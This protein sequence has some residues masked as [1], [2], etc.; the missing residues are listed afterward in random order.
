MAKKS[1]KAATKK[2]KTRRVVSRRKVA[3]R[4]KTKAKVRDKARPTAKKRARAKPARKSE[5]HGIFAKVSGALH[6]FADTVEEV[7]K[8]EKKQLPDAGKA[9]EE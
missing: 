6:T 2:K 4:A 5:P 7:M 1:R 9:V 3:R 8:L